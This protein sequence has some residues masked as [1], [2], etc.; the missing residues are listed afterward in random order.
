MS[1]IYIP[2]EGLEGYSGFSG[3]SGVSG[4]SGIHGPTSLSLNDLHNEYNPEYK[5]SHTKPCSICCGRGKVE[6]QGWFGKIKLV[7]CRCK[8][9]S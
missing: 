3:C 8:N 4:Y 6:K 1:L 5:N 2:K 9:G 7:K